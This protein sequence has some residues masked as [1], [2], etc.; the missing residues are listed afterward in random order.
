[1]EKNIYQ[2]VYIDRNLEKDRDHCY[3]IGKYRGAAHNIWNLRF[4]RPNEIPP[5]SQNGSN[6][7]YYFIIK[8][9]ATEFEQKFKC[10]AKNTRKYKNFSVPRVKKT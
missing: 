7:I 6:Y 2:R 1:M 4:N 3:Y 5:I 8:E 9:L 10:L